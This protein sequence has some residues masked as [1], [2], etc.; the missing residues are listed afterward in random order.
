[1]VQFLSIIFFFDFFNFCWVFLKVPFFCVILYIT[2]ARIPFIVAR[3]QPGLFIPALYL[4]LLRVS[5]PQ[6]QQ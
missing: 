2:K 1:M 3:I 4:A 5:V 6:Y